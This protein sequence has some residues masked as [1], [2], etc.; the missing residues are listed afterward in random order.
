MTE[1]RPTTDSELVEFVHAIDVRA[2]DSVH[3]HVQSLVAAS[4]A[5][6][7]GRRRV[8]LFGADDG[9]PARTG[10]R[11]AAIG[12]ITAA[13]IALVIAASLGGGGSSSLSIHAASA[14]TLS[15]ATAPAPTD[16]LDHRAQLAAA[17]DGVAFPYWGDRFGW[18]STGSRSDRVAGR[19]ITTVFYSD[20]RG[21]RIGYAIVAGA[22]A[23]RVSGGVTVWR[24]GTPYR[25]LAENGAAA[26]SWLR[27][28]HLCVISGRGVDG[29][30]LLRLAS[31][32]GSRAQAS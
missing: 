12:A 26:V 1:Q 22:P 15:P 29:A 21:R 2:P 7:G 18:S 9:R 19:A 11:I 13:V 10:P 32:N 30:T 28:G 16:S 25:L 27:D 24:G 14:L 5:H 31:W 6:A 17:V 20:A 4:S 23:P 8:R 3:R